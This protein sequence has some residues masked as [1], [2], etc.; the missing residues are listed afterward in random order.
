MQFIKSLK[1]ILLKRM[2]FAVNHEFEGKTGLG[3]GVRL[4]G[5]DAFPYGRVNLREEDVCLRQH[6][7][8]MR[9][10]E[11][12]HVRQRVVFSPESLLGSGPTRRL[13]SIQY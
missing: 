7:V 1:A 11:F 13:N 5:A 9:D 2:Y 12:I 6:G 4:G 8:N 10:I 3:V